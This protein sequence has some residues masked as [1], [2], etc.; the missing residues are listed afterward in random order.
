MP[1][2]S[3]A[4][5]ATFSLSESGNYSIQTALEAVRSHLGMDIA[6]LSEFVDGRS[7]FREISAPGLGDM[8]K[9]GDSHSL[10][11]VYCQHILN[12]TLPELI[13]DTG[14]NAF[15][16]SMPITQAVPI[17]SHMSIPIRRPDGSAYGMFC[18]LSTRP[19]PSL[20]SRDL[21]TMRMFADLAAYQVVTELEASAEFEKK[22]QTI[23]RV[24]ETSEF[25]IV[26][27]P[28]WDLATMQPAGFESLCRFT[29]KPYRSPDLWFADA[30]ETG[31]GVDLELAVLKQALKGFD[32]MPAPTY[33]AFNVSPETVLSGRLGEVLAD[34]PLDRVV[35]EIT[36]HAPVTDYAT[37]VS[38]IRTFTDSGAR[39]AID[40]AGAGYSSLRHIVQLAPD[41]IKLDMSISRDIDTDQSR[42]SLAA[43]LI[44]FARETG[45]TIIAEGVE[46][47]TELETL[48]SLGVMRVQ[49]YLLGK[50]QDLQSAAA[51]VT[52]HAAHDGKTVRA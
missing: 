33:I 3:A 15:A 10:E 27:Q 23:R 37:L 22:R 19:N 1:D 9:V 51:L 29:A 49:G 38:A 47:Q 52:Q 16:L 34:A 44:Y 41:L 36:E 39:L 26:Y 45:A 24:I 50:P 13:P 17:G 4:V 20:N 48:R 14:Q 30:A 8:V 21:A 7:V 6:Y 11:D 35:I 43:A 31:L 28:I 40:D 2:T 32:A 42:R 46:T 18:C 25:S 12:G 5:P